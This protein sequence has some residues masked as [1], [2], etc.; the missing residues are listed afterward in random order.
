MSNFNIIIGGYFNYYGTFDF[1]QLSNTGSVIFDGDIQSINNYNSGSGIFNNVVFS[2]STSATLVNEG[3][4]VV[5]DLTIEQ[6]NFNSADYTVTVGGN[7]DNSGGPYTRDKQVIFDSSGD[8]QDM[9]GTNTSND[10]HQ[11]TY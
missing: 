7:W 4:T 5:G 2:A 11:V 3:I 10:V 1:T 8:H 6:G 9:S